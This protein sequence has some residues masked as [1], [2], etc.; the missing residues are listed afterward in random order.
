MRRSV[1]ILAIAAVALVS[2]GSVATSATVALGTVTVDGA[3]DEKP[4]LT[5]A[6]PLATKKTTHR[7]VTAGSGEKLAKGSKITFD[8]LVV[9]GRTGDE[10]GASFGTAP[11]SAVLD[12]SQTAAGL[13]KSLV[14]AP[15][16]SRVLIAIAPKEGLAENARKNGAAGVKK[17]D[18]LLFLVDVKSASTP[19]KR[20]TGTTVEPVAGLP[21]V[22]LAKAGKPTIT[23][24]G[25]KAPTEL[26]VQP[27]IEGD[28]AA[29]T[30]GQS[31]TVHYTGLV[32]KNGKQFDSSWDRGAPAEFSIGTGNVI[33]GWDSALVGQPV[34]SQVLLVIPPD[35]G[36]GANGNPNAGIAGTDTLV[37]VVDILDAS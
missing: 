30:A 28:G 12:T 16:G 14:G 26:V 35:L 19:L 21:K 5:F 9:D 10:L 7:V 8:Y 18:T 22:S 1:T 20:A 23:V 33:A 37:F 17:D 13:V 3:I 34:G 32:W 29:V 25:G 27:L 15:I 4:T 6:T 11:V 36:Y 2:F 24:P 31:I